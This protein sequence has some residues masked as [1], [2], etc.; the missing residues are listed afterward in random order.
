MSNIEYFI[1]D[2]TVVHRK[3]IIVNSSKE[4]KLLKVLNQG[5]LLKIVMIPKKTEK[6][7]IFEHLKVEDLEI[8]EIK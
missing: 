4:D 3:L 7:L 2:Q 8:L 1:E 5:E 6:E